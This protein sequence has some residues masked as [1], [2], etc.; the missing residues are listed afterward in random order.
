MGVGTTIHYV[1]RL[2]GRTVDTTFKVT[3]YEVNRKR[4]N[5]SLSGPYPYEITNRFESVNGGT[6]FTATAQ[7]DIGGFFKLAEPLVG[8]IIDRQVDTGFANLKDLLEAQA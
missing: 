4:V 5:K 7:L 1:A 3:E 2:L 6:Q 8:R